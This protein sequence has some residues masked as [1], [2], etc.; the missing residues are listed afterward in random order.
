MGDRGARIWSRKFILILL[1]SGVLGKPDS[2]DITHPPPGGA[3]AAAET[4]IESRDLL[5]VVVDEEDLDGRSAYVNNQFI[6]NDPV[7]LGDDEQNAPLYEILQKQMEQVLASTGPDVPIYEQKN[8]EAK[9]PRAASGGAAQQLPTRPPLFSQQIQN[10]AELDDDYDDEQDAAD[11]IYGDAEKPDPASTSD[12]EDQES[13]QAET[14]YQSAP[15]LSKPSSSLSSS[16][17]GK[18]SS[19]RRP[20]RRR[21]TTTTTTTST[22]TTIQ[23][24]TTRYRNSGQT[25]ITTTSPATA[26]LNQ[27]SLNPFN[28]TT[29]PRPNTKPSQSQTNNLNALPHDPQIYQHK[30]RIVFKTIS[31]G[32]QFVTSPIGDLMIKFSIGF[33]KPQSSQGLTPPTTEALRTLSNNLLRNIELQKLKR[34]NK[35][36][37]H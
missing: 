25:K 31:T 35:V 8:D 2:E 18:P 28:S 36:Q 7:E 4:K 14:G 29:K 3:A 30:R 12:E 20:H 15:Q 16:F 19:T 34:S 11:Q 10:D 9:P 6:P 24:R 5:D 22:T 13:P 1:L 23:P 17:G 32:S 27:T 33:A 37:R 21:T 26:S